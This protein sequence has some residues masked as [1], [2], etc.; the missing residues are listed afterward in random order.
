VLEREL[1][2]SMGGA[3]HD[4]ADLGL[5]VLECEIR[6]SG[7]WNTEVRE[8]TFHPYLRKLSFEEVFY[9]SGKLG[10]G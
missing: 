3:K 5:F 7:L 2:E 6:V 10:D 9:L 8:L 4:R 1:E